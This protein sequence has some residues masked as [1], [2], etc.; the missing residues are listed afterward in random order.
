MTITQ[1]SLLVVSGLHSNA[2][3]RPLD[4]DIINLKRQIQTNKQ[5][6]SQDRF[7][8]QVGINDVRGL[9]VGFILFYY[10]IFTC[11][12][13]SRVYGVHWIFE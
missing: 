6:I 13:T 10:K 4:M 3:L 7:D 9:E 8:L 12:R 1:E 5:N 11:T 2:H